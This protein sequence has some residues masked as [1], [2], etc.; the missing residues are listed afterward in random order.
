MLVFNQRYNKN[1]MQ[2]DKLFHA[3]QKIGRTKLC[4]K[5]RKT[6]QSVPFCTVQI[7]LTCTMAIVSNISY[8]QPPLRAW[9]VEFGPY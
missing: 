1:Y 8:P 3:A 2:I 4:P 7:L 6:E 5:Y 9:P